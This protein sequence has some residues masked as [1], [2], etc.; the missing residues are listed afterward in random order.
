MNVPMTEKEMMPCGCEIVKFW[1]ALRVGDTCNA[2]DTM[3]VERHSCKKDDCPMD[4]LK[5]ET[6]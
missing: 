2:S 3:R 4:Y 6:D 5:N 1:N